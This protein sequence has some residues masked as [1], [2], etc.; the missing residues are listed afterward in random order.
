MKRLPTMTTTTSISQFASRCAALMELALTFC[1]VSGRAEAAPQDTGQ[2][3]QAGQAEPAPRANPTP[4]IPISDAYVL[5]PGDEVSISVTP[6]SEWDCSGVV[7]P[8]GMLYLKGLGAVRAAA[9]RVPELEEQLVK[10]L[11]LKKLRKP[12][13]HVT[14]TR[15]APPLPS[16]MITVSGSVVR[17]GL[18]TL[19]EG[20]RLGRVIELSGG[21]GQEADLSKIVVIHK[22]LTRSEADLSTTELRSDPKQ[23]LLL[24]EGD[25]VY[26][27]AII[28]IPVLVTLSGAVAKAG[29][30]QMEEAP[31]VFKAIELAGGANKDADLSKVSVR[32]KD[33]TTTIVDLSTGQKISDPAHNLQL[34][35]GDSVD[36]PSLYKD[37]NVAIDGAVA[38]PG[39]FELRPNWAVEDLILAA[40]KLNLLAD[41][42]HIRVRRAG[43]DTNVN[44]LAQHEMGGERFLLEPGD[45]VQVPVYKNTVLLA[46]AI[47]APGLRPIKPGQTIYEFLTNGSAENATALD[48]SKLDLRNSQLIRNGQDAI[49]VNIRDIMKKPKGNK[50]NF[51]LQSGDILYLPAKEPKAPNPLQLLIPAVS[52][53]GQIFRGGLF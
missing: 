36:V 3:G 4:V 6:R 7:A 15:L 13:V 38:N 8:D 28:K 43:K 10:A 46:G 26:V 47:S 48:N 9:L 39:T 49:K 44:L 50:Q 30:I 25:S 29:P 45:T 14:L 20:L 40:G 33:L 42:E 41:V 35:D 52:V 17:P 19:E 16:N 21:A 27:P 31:R 53:L 51:A 32:H 1:L 2:T 5:Q 24:K 23:N 34:V 12:A 37:G 11:K 18:A 22:D